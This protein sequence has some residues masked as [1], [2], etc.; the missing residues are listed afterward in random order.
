[1]IIELG[2]FALM[3]AC[4]LSLVLGSLGL[5]AGL[6]QHAVGMSLVKPMAWLMG[7]GIALSYAALTWAFIDNDFS[8]EYVAA[9][10]HSLLPWWYRIAAVWGGHE[11]SLL[12][13]VLFLALWLLAV[14]FSNEQLPRNVQVLVVAIL[15]W[16]TFGIL[17]FILFTSNPF[18]RMPEVPFEGLDLN[19]LLQDVGLIIHPPLLYLGYVGFSV[20]FAFAMT[21]LLLGR[22]DATWA[23][24]SRPWTMAA[25]A[26]LTLGILVGS[27]WAYYELGWGGWWFWDPVENASFMPWL[28]GT[29]LMHSLAV[30]EKRGSFKRWTVLLAILTFSLSLLGMFI[31]RSGVLTSVHSFATDPGRGLFILIFLAIVV[32]GAL[33]L[34]TWRVPQLLTHVSFNLLSRE[35]GLLANNVFLVTACASVFIGTLFPLVMDIIDG[36]KFSVGPPY[37]NRIFVPIML[38]MM[39]FMG[40]TVF[41]SWRRQKNNAWLN[42]AAILA[43]AAIVLGALLP[44]IM[45]E[46]RWG[47]AVASALALWVIFTSLND[48]LKRVQLTRNKRSWFTTLRK[49]PRSF[50]GMHLAHMGLGVFVLGAAWAT[51][52]ASEEHRKVAPNETVTVAGYEL[53]F[54]NLEAIQGPNYQSLMAHFLV[55]KNGKPIYW[56]KPEKRKYVSSELP[57]TEASLYHTIFEDVYVSMGEMLGDDLNTSP[58][59]M[60]FYYRPLM[61]WVWYGAILMALGAFVSMTDRRYRARLPSKKKREKKKVVQV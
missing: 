23:R 40:L 27:I 1:M 9:Q 11:G 57:M 17:L 13:L 10:S 5:W 18:L 35:T 6:K 61:G 32:G 19:P 8:L 44:F 4:V 47:V 33:A 60:R 37:F 49:Q 42:R 22:L 2:H 39:V 29:A 24:Y 46:W 53:T 12:L 3:L 48:L 58:W 15:S 50:L 55:T 16:I 38:S 14:C 20:A 34:Y 52:Y 43:L 7:I 41:L 56:L 51:G 45:A 31:V 30:T 54:K 28:A 26:F 59:L 25:W 36:G 21:A